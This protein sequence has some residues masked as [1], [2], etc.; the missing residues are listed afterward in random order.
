MV[1]T[2]HPSGRVTRQRETWPD[3]CRGLAVFVVLL[4]HIRFFAANSVGG[5]P[6]WALS[7]NAFMAPFYLPALFFIAGYFVP[8][9]MRRGAVA[10]TR[11]KISAIGW[12]LFVWNLINT[13]RGGDITDPHD[14]LTVSYLWF[15]AY[16][17]V[18]CIVAVLVR[19]IPAWIVL[20][21]SIALPAIA[22]PPEWMGRSL[23][24]AAYFFFGVLACSYRDHIPQWAR[25]SWAWAV[26]PAG[27]PTGIYCVMQ[28]SVSPPVIQVISLVAISAGVVVAV[29]LS[30]YPRLAQ[31]W[32]WLGQHSLEFYVLHWQIGLL[33]S[34][35]WPTFS[36]VWLGFAVIGTAVLG[37]TLAAVVV[38][39][40]RPLSYLFSLRG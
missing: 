37:L 11:G 25:H 35:L 15:L 38:F 9:S 34:P 1:T 3:V 6:D 24:F 14:L 4:V 12:P 30:A 36:H 8:L 40:R 22:T 19:R 13:A 33:I 17:L 31:P 26:I 28:G 20:A 16:L 2:K 27:V 18:Y 21:V 32:V 5:V 10:F 23:S 39:R 29:R 7:F